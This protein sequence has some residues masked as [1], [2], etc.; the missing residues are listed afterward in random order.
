MMK[1]VLVTGAC[2]NTGVA[3]VEKFAAEGYN[4]VFTGRNQLTVSEMEKAYRTQFPEVQITGYA[5]HSLNEDGSVNE[6][7]VNELFAASDQ[8]NVSIQVLVLN[9]ADQGLNMKIFG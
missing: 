3:I 5:L 9:A 8:N 6:P 2:I 4:I 1:T 7:D